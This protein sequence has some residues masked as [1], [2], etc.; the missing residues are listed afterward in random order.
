M[1][2][3][4]KSEEKKTKGRNAL[5]SYFEE[6]Y[7]ELKKVTWT[8]R[9]QAIR[10][11]FIVIGFCIVASLFVGALD[12]G[13]NQGYQSLV[14][15]AEKVAPVTAA[16]ATPAKNNTTSNPITITPGD[17]TATTSTQQ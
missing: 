7:Q 14:K 9:N 15:F 12:L 1:T 10:L 17:I 8:P 4:V 5:L 3:H 11:T 13:F 6:S 2:E 16:P